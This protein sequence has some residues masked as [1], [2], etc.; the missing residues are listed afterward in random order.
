MC[1]YIYINIIVLVALYCMIIVHAITHLNTNYILIYTYI[2]YIHIYIYT[3]TIY[4]YT[5]MK[6]YTNADTNMCIH[7]TII[8]MLIIYI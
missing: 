3:H 5:C 7:I 2:G 1:V 4:T 8:V 6:E